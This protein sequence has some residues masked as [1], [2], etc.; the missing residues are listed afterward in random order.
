MHNIFI[1]LYNNKKGH[2]FVLLSLTFQHVIKYYYSSFSAPNKLETLH[3]R[4]W[5]RHRHNFASISIFIT[6]FLRLIAPCVCV[7]VCKCLVWLHWSWSELWKSW[8]TNYLANKKGYLFDFFY[9]MI[10]SCAL[11]IVVYRSGEGTTSNVWWHRF[12]CTFLSFESNM[13]MFLIPSSIFCTTINN[14]I[15]VVSLSRDMK[16]VVRNI[17][18]IGR[19]CMKF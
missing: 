8:Q 15:K 4:T 1:H 7:C 19:K 9:R 6:P 13:N 18:K 14:I 17:L 10:M 5:H 11:P 3:H 12:S 16:S 2:S